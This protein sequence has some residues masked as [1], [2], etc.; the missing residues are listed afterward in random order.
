M[1]FELMPQPT[2]YNAVV[3][4]A[5]SEVIGLA[6]GFGTNPGS[7]GYFYY[8]VNLMILSGSSISSVL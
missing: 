3:V 5:N 4:V 6:P 7:F 8:L 1:Y 2:R